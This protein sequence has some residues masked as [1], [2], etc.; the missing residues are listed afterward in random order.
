LHRFLD[1][2]RG[3]DVLQLDA[4]DLDAPFVGRFVEDRGDLGVDDVS[5][6]EGRVE[7]EVA[8]DVPEGGRRQV[9]DRRNRAVNAV[10]EQL[11][12][13]NQVEDDGVDLHRD[14]VLGDDRLG[15]EIDD[16]FLEGNLLRNPLDEGDFEV[17]AGL[18]GRF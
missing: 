16:V 2:P 5:G 12:I 15:R 18:P 8:D 9:L 6:G 13:G 4:G 7:V 10:G 14:V 17:D 1:L 3:H 11:R